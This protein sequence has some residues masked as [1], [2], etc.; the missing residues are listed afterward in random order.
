[1]T[2][3]VRIV[4]GRA[5]GGAKQRPIGVKSE[6]KYDKRTYEREYYHRVRKLKTGKQVLSRELKETRRRAQRAYYWRNVERERA[7]A[8][9]RMRRLHAKRKPA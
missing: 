3:T 8:R 2:T 1:M 4:E 6:G 7:A 5:Y 9:E